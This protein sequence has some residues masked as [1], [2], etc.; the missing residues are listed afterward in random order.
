MNPSDPMIRF[1]ELCAGR[2][3]GDLSMEEARELAAL[4]KQLGIDPDNAFEL[5]ATTLEVE[6]IQASTEPMPAHLAA[7]LQR[8]A[9]ETASSKP[10][11]II[12][13]HVPTWKIIA[14]NP[15]S[16]WAAAAAILM[17]SLLV[18]RNE[19]PQSASQTEAGL[20]AEATDLIERNFAG[21][22]DFKQAS[23]T[24]IWSD[25]RQQGFMTLSGIPANDPKKAQYQLWIVDPTRDADAPVDGGVFDIPN[26]GSPIVI[27]ITAKLALQRPQAFVITLEKP[28]GVVKS[29]Q[30]KVVALAKG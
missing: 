20:R 13:P 28:G 2:A 11:N 29:K 15:I 7:S 23:G 10:Q 1:D 4:S 27:P 5:L 8:W 3:M 25:Q 19:S 30:E 16:G 21:L 22:G 17:L 9:D 24:V 26:D 18:L 14:R 12:T 6:S